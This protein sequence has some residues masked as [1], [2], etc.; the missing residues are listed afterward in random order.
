MKT[1]T[2]K[3]IAPVIITILLVLYLA[4]YMILT[5]ISA[6]AIG[7]MGIIFAA[8]AAGGI[9]LSIYTL[10]ERI[11]EIRNGDEDDLSKY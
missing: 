2:K 11:K 5:L 4:V 7:I 6:L 1:H 3:I 9:M 10:I 8:V